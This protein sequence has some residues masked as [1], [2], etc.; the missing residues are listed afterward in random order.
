MTAFR[1]PGRL[2][3]G[4]VQL[5][6]GRLALGLEDALLGDDRQVAVFQRD[7]VEPS[8]PV[9]RVGEVQLLGAGDVL[10]DQVAQVALAGDE[11]DDRDRPVGRLRLDQLRQ[12]LPLLVDELQVRRRALASQ[13]ISS[14]RNRISA[15]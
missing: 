15:S 14:S 2:L 1:H 5:L 6:P 8:L 12:L 4:R 9:E 7:R 10:A 11:A 13:R 3:E